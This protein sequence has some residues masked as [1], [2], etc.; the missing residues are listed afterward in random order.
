MTEE[1]RGQHRQAEEAGWQTGE[2]VEREIQVCKM[3]EG[4]N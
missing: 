2:L 4:G 3:R 1:Q